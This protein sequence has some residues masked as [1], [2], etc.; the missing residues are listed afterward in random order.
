MLILEKP[1]VSETLIK[2]AIE[3][4]L[5]VLR[6]AMSE[7]LAAQGYALKLYDDEAFI[8]EY[9]KRHRVYTM[10]ENALGWIVEKLP[11]SELL[12]KIS[13][14][15]N[16][17][18][19]RRICKEMYPDFFFQ[20]VAISEMSDMDV[21]AMPFPLVLKPSVGFLSAG[22]YVVHDEEEWS[23]AVTDIVA[24]F[25]KVGAQ[26]PEYVVGTRNFLL[27]EYI[28]GEEYAVDAYFDEKGEPV[29]WNIYHHRFA[30]E[31][32]TSDR[33]YCSSRKLYDRYERP[34]MD[35][36]IQTNRVIG[37]R[38]FPMHIEFRYDGKK[39]IPIE[40]NPLRFAGFCL[41]EL[42][43]H[44]SGIHPV[45]AYLNNIHITK[46]EMWKGKENDTYNFL[47]LERPAGVSKESQFDSDKFKSSVMDVLELRPLSDATAGVAATAFTRVDAAH[48]AEFDFI[49]NL[50]MRAFMKS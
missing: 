14:L 12:Q 17:A 48:E 28:K 13:L 18:T 38:D 2:T 50:D 41:N 36:L 5:P 21:S 15:K 1:Y 6:N 30:N 46:E 24:N 45:L 37:L 27:E 43:T 31:S 10:S 16:K 47:V 22:V 44:I 3:N 20:E 34:F 26:F 8:A 29:I 40:I 35:F 25:K 4:D 7:Q 39:A 23:V 33:L 19:F 32:D 9:Q 49:L 11:D 42:Q